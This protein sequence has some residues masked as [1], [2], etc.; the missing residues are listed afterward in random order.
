M[1]PTMQVL[2]SSLEN[3]KIQALMG[4]VLR[5]QVDWLRQVPKMR[6]LLG[7]MMQGLT[8]LEDEH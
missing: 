3:Q 2:L 1:G 8:M 7:L 5:K 4:M 6:G